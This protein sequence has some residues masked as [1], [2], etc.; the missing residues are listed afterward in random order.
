M[1][2]CAVSTEHSQGNE[3]EEED[4]LVMDYLSSSVTQLPWGDKDQSRR[5]TGICSVV[6]QWCVTRQVLLRD[7]LRS[8]RTHIH[9]RARAH[10]HTNLR[11]A[12][13]H[14]HTH[15]CAGSHKHERVHAPVSARA[16]VRTRTHR[17]TNGQT[18]RLTDTQGH[19]RTGS[20]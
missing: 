18:Q 7:G 15:I 10:T 20:C 12:Q 17:Q 9:T 19:V 14:M 8:T 13:A 5:A 3:E 2:S 6:G 1:A 16:L 4:A 11:A